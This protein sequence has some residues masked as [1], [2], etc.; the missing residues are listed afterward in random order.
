MGLHWGSPHDLQSDAQA[1]GKLQSGR[2]PVLPPHRAEWQRR[3]LRGLVTVAVSCWV[4]EEP[5]PH[6]PVQR[7]TQTTEL[8]RALSSGSCADR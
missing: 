4:P 6:I 1:W 3:V 7:H 8:C 2:F 5:L